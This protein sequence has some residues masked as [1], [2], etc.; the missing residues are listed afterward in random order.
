MSG[1]GIVRDDL[2]IEHEPGTWHPESPDRL[3]AI[4]S[5]LDENK[6]PLINLERREATEK[7]I[8]LVHT[9]EHFKRVSLTDGKSSSRFDADTA[10][11][12]MSFRAAL[13][14]AGGLINLTEKVV[15]RELDNGFALVRPP[16]HH[17]E[18]GRAMGFCFFNN[19][20]VAAAWALS[21]MGLSR[22]LIVDWDLHHGN[23]TQHSFYKDPRVLYISTHQYPHYPG[24]G[25]LG[26]TGRDEG[27]GY[28][29]NIPLSWGHGNLEYV[30]I[31]QKIVEPAARAFKPDLILVSAGFDI[32]QQD[33]LGDMKITDEGFAAM[34]HILK[35]VAAEVCQGRLVFTLEG[36]YHIR[37][38]ADGVG[39]VLDVL[40]EKNATGRDL[41]EQD[42]A[43]PVIVGQVRKIQ[44]QFWKF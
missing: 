17:A 6:R 32:H 36:G 16:G 28:N 15:N 27:L 33:P 5:L 23:G 37:G 43:E 26:E 30:S 9:S 41:A 14:A 18:A 8:T 29:I 39:Q 24:T 20:A 34:A 4:Y 38:Q 3:K 13:A 31:F 35:R 44:S 42:I 12:A 11:S 21:H 22:V 2:F 40:T 7:E 19:V 10:A 25:G 1:T